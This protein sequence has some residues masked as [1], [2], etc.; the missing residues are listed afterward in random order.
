MEYFGDWSESEI[1]SAGGSVRAKIGE[2]G[3]VGVST[4]VGSFSESFCTRES[5]V[6]DFGI[7]SD[8]G[9]GGG[10]KGVHA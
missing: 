3:R 9:I 7:W 10:G 4:I 2:F 6:E 1:V 5:A 8:S